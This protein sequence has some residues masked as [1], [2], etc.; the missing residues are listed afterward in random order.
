ML[1]KSGYFSTSGSICFL[2]TLNEKWYNKQMTT[3]LFL[4]QISFMTIIIFGVGF[5]IRYFTKGDLSL[6]RLIGALIG[7]ILL[8]SSLVWRNVKK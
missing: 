5:F 1:S 3:N 2:V 7:C 6:D 4:I 8:I